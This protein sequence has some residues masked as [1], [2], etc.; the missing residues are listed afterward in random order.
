MLETIKQYI[1]MMIEKINNIIID[2]GE[3]KGSKEIKGNKL[4]N[5]LQT[6]IILI[7][8]AYIFAK[9]IS[10]FNVHFNYTFQ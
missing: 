8:L 9:F 4:M 7:A 10:V 3:G 6:I 2:N 5:G 1:N